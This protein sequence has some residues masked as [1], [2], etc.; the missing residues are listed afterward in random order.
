[1]RI[2]CSLLVLVAIGYF[3]VPALLRRLIKWRL[4]GYVRDANHVDVTQPERLPGST[5][6]R[7]AVLGGGVAGLTAAVTLARRGFQVVVYDANSYLGGKLG[8]WP[9]ELAPGRTVWVSHGFHAFFPN[10]FNL[11]RFLDSLG[12]RRSFKSIGDYVI[13]GYQHTVRF[14]NLDRT[15]VFN[16]FSLARAGVFKVGEAL[17]APGRDFYGVFMEYDHATNFQKYDHLSFAQFDRLAK[18]PPQLKLAFNT[19]ARAFF[20]DEDKLSFAE[21]LKSFHFYYLGQDGGLVYEYPEE[22][23]ETALLA[24]IREELRS[25]QA[26]LRL[27][28]RVHA[29]SRETTGGF[30]IDGEAFDKVIVA[31]DVVGANAILSKATGI[32]EAL[33]QQFSK[34]TPGQRYA[35]LRV[36]VDKDVRNDIP[37]FV[38]TDRVKVLDAVSVY[39]R[40]EPAIREEL[41]AHPGFVLELHCY[42]VPDAMEHQEVRDALLEE[43]QVLFPETRGLEVEHEVFQLKRDFTAFHVG[44][45]ATRPTVETSVPGLYCA[46]DW[47]ALPFPA[48]LLECACASGLWAAN[49]VLREEGLRE[50][51]VRS[52]GLRGLLAGAPQ[53][54]GRQGLDAPPPAVP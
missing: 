12:L 6:R 49:A 37:V 45:G 20:A 47:V 35:V 17:R 50:E 39:H 11:N 30:T 13:V 19:F 32:P 8:S 16:L 9:V 43:L 27:S 29:L 23:Y 18:V 14:A 25:H 10:Y 2:L 21:L 31:T 51:Q 7:V 28:T 24:P 42:A 1:M 34:L 26:Q 3:V 4:G 33:A 41:E 53:P 54:P 38:I 48:M 44:Q 40:I 22:D 46:G 52:V 36:W 5:P 15:P